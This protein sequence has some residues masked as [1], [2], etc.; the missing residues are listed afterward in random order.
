MKLTRTVPR[1]VLAAVIVT[2]PT[3]SA[4][5]GDDGNSVAQE[6]LVQER[7]QQERREAGRLARQEERLQRLETELRKNSRTQPAPAPPPTETAGPPSTVTEDGASDTDT[8]ESWPSGTNAWTVVLASATSPA[9]AEATAGRA[10][11]AGLPQVGVLL[12]DNHSSLHR[13]YWV[14]YTGVLDRSEASQ[15]ASDA[16]AL[17]F[18]D[19]Y[20]RFVSA[21]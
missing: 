17:G 19:A 18:T 14:A 5:G 1:V 6:Q 12:S 7:I 10:S 8:S 2:L 4:C 11:T 20:A 3:F 21:R 16:H 13:G 15:R 9:G